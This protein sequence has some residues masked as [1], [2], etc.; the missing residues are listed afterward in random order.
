MIGSNSCMGSEVK[1]ASVVFLV[2]NM[3]MNDCLAVKPW[4]T[5]NLELV[6]LDAPSK[7][8]PLG[9]AIESASRLASCFIDKVY[10][11]YLLKCGESFHF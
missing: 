7:S 2:H 6:D 5:I 11:R 8:L 10:L 9:E 4:L 1:T 3:D